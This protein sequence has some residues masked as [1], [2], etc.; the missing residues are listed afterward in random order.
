MRAA[1]G[2][3]GEDTFGSVRRLYKDASERRREV[4]EPKT[5]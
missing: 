5:G 1:S 4:K 2:F 3:A